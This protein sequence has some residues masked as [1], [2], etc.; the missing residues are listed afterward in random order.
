M[1]LVSLTTFS[2]AYES[3]LGIAYNQA[4]SYNQGEGCL[5]N[6][7]S[8]EP[9]CTED[10]DPDTMEPYYKEHSSSKSQITSLN[11]LEVM[12]YTFV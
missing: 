6:D 3:A 5:E 4:T 1:L 2:P 7:G 8:V 12:I 10:V 9:D 11:G